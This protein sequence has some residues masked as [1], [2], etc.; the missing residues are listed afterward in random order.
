[1][2]NPAST[3]DIEVRWRPLTAQESTNAEA[4]LADAWATILGRR[5]TIDADI[6]AD[7]VSVDNVVKVVCAMVLRVLKNPDGYSQERIDDWSGTRDALTGSGL[8]TITPGEL[9]DITPGR[10][11]NRSIRLTIYGTT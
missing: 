7:T 10:Q 11:S 3:T 2:P 6:A 8:M 5:P 1:M 4:F 9:A